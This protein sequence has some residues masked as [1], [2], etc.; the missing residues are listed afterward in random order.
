MT[1]LEVVALV[2]GSI[3]ALVAVGGMLLPLIAWFSGW[4]R[5]AEEFR[6]R[7]DTRGGIVLGS[8]TMRYGAHYGGVIRLDGCPTGLVLSVRAPFRLAHPPLLIPW[9][10]VIAEP[11][12]VLGIF[13]AT[14]LE[15]GQDARI[16][17]TF[18]NNEARERVA[19]FI[20]KLHPS[21]PG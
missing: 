8:A 12:N 1:P 2:A 4:R 7:P 10:Q 15:L 17:L 6:A 19:Q 13:P 20:T 5:L 16:P 21:E 18:Y 3:A 14:R 11:T 9:L